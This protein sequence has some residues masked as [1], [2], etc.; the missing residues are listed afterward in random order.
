MYILFV[1]I[2]ITSTS[3]SCNFS[4]L[5]FPKLT[6]NKTTSGD[7]IYVFAL[8]YNVLRIT[9]GMGGVV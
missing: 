6:F 2:L 7:Q 8:N 9:S 5:D 3:G 4:R 1:Y